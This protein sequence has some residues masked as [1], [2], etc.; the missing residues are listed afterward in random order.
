[1]LQ[2]P[3]VVVPFGVV[4]GFSGVGHRNEKYN[5]MVKELVLI[6]LSCAVWGRQLAGS[7]VLIE[8]DNSSVV[9]AVNKHYTRE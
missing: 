4:N 5:I 1:M 2:E 8:C 9:A 6:V 3:G 7:P